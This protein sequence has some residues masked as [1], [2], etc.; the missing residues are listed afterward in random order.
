MGVMSSMHPGVLV[1]THDQLCAHP[2]TRRLC[3]FLRYPEAAA[4]AVLVAGEMGRDVGELMLVARRGVAGGT[5][6]ITP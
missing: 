6:G 3:Y 5:V 4:V 1:D 2:V